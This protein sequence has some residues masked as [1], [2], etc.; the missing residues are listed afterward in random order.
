[1]Q[2]NK[3]GSNNNKQQMKNNKI[4]AK[5]I[6]QSIPAAINHKVECIEFLIT[7]IFSSVT[8]M[9]S[10]PLTEAFVTRKDL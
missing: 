9:L 4:Y 5:P 2:L 3:Q 10:V 1:M 7:A 6:T 8:P